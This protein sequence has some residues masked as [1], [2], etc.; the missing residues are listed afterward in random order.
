MQGIILLWFGEI[1]ELPFSWHECDGTHGTPDLRNKW[2]RGAGNTFAVNEYGGFKNHRHPFTS[3]I[4]T[5]NI[6]PYTGPL[7]AGT[8]FDETTH[9]DVVTGFTG[10][11]NAVPPY[12]CLVY[13]QKL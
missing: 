11:A 2:I 5:H 3:N 1:A 13:I 4:H 7:Q 6:P 9:A 10:F 8:G 12:H